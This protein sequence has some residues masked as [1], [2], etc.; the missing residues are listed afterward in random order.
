MKFFYLL[1]NLFLLSKASPYL[2]Y[3]INDNTYVEFLTQ[4]EGKTTE[5]LAS[6]GPFLE[7]STAYDVRYIINTYDF[8][9]VR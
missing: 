7:Y 2:E 5:N 4:Y 3:Q 6:G 9:L 1:L 8:I